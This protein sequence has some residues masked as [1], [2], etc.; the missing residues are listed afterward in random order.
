MPWPGS[1][2]AA[3]ERATIPEALAVLPV[4]QSAFRCA[5]GDHDWAQMTTGRSG[6]VNWDR[7]ARGC[8]TTRI[9]KGRR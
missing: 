2:Y 3:P 6:Y 7:C 1:R 8:G 4:F 9:V 5:I